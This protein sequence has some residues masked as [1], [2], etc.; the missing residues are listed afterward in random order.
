M[1]N[2]RKQCAP[3]IAR[4]AG[5]AFR[6]LL[7]AA[8]VS[9]GVSLGSGCS[10]ERGQDA[11][12]GEIHR[13][14]AAANAPHELVL[15]PGGIATLQLLRADGRRIRIEADLSGSKAVNI[16]RRSWSNR[17]DIS[18]EPGARASVKLLVGAV[19]LNNIPRT[20][21]LLAVRVCP[22]EP[23]TCPAEPFER[24]TLEVELPQEEG[25]DT[26]SA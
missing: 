3:H 10:G 23:A 12:I 18:G 19:G 22:A 15:A 11:P 25:P 16:Q 24:V 1:R 20:N 13:Y 8:F 4:T 5:I 6:A 17:L 14:D 26:E 7:V 21:V 2:Q 9:G